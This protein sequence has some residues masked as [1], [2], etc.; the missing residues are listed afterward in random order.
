MSVLEFRNFY[1]DALLDLVW[2]QWTNLGISGQVG[3]TDSDYVYDPEMLLIFSA[4]FC[5]YDARLYDLIIDW[6]RNNGAFISITRLKALMKSVAWCDSASLGFMFRCLANSGER[7]WKKFADELM[8]SE[9][10]KAQTLFLTIDGKANDFLKSKNK[11]ALQYAYLRSPY[12][13]SDK[14]SSFSPTAKAAFLLQLRGAFGLSVRA[15]AIL[16]LLNQDVCRIQDIVDISYFSWKTVQ[17]TMHNLCASSLVK[18]HEGTKRGTYYFIKEPQK[19]L[20]LWDKENADFP[21]WKNIFNALALIWQTVSN[22][23]LA[24][25]S[26]ATFHS[27]I[28]RVFTEQIKDSL[29]NARI[30]ALRFFSPEDIK[31][32]P[33]IIAAIS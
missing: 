6:L 19:F 24:K 17:D 16:A 8:P 23:K 29:L 22:P 31:Q 9:D 10:T 25:L 26:E 28:K 7:R 20:T 21:D 3:T 33:E 11:Q 14:T 30:P 18:S 15:E 2:R 4:W 12:I 5:R 32:L 1:F 13:P 27:E